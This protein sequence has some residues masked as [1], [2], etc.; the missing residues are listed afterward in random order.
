MRRRLFAPVPPTDAFKSRYPTAMSMRPSQL[1][2]AAAES[3]MLV[4]AVLALRR[5]Y[6]QLSVPAVLVAGAED[7]Y[8]DTRWHS[9]R[10]HRRLDHSWLRVVE[11]SGH[12][13]HHVA[14]GQV[15]AAIDQAA[16][17]VW[18]RSLLLRAPAGLKAGGQGQAPIPFAFVPC[19]TT[20]TIA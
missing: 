3:A 13:V 19:A 6:A 9:G 7:R 20:A 4:P 14:P 11:G 15:M 18:D 16:G 5:R 12:M 10:L 1:H 2:A 8:L 17:I